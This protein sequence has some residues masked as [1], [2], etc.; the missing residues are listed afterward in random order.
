MPKKQW[1]YTPPEAQVGVYTLP[2][3]F[4]LSEYLDEEK[5]EFEIV[6]RVDPEGDIYFGDNDD[7]IF[8]HPR[9]L[10]DLISLLQDLEKRLDG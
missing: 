5:D 4:A 10:P 7:G 6:V 8:F 3:R 1:T 2:V 9:Y